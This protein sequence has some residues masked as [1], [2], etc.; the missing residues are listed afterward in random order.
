MRVAGLFDIHGNLPALEAVLADLEGEDVDTIVLGGD[1]ASGPMPAETLA[2]LRSQSVPLRFVRGNADQVLDFA[3]FP[4]EDLPLWKRSRLWVAERL[5]DEDLSFLAGLPLDVVVDVDGLG[6][7]RFCHGAPGSDELVITKV[8]PNER[9]RRLLEG[10]G[11]RVVVCGHTHVQFDR[12]VDGVR[13]VNAGSVGA[14]YEAAPGAYWLL[15]GPEIEHRRTRYDVERAVSR[16]EATGFPRAMEY[17][18]ELPLEDPARPER[19][20]ALIEANA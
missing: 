2:L 16:I 13:V 18:A 3:S 17:A 5:G 19:M 10:V 20:S 12:S 11:E 8:T 6:S 7:T 15:A 9:L 4:G 1:V 14:P